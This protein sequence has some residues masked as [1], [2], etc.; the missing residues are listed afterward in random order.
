MSQERKNN[1][2]KEDAVLLLNR[3]KRGLMRIVFGRTALIILLLAVQVLFLFT[4]FFRLLGQSHLLALAGSGVISLIM[5]LIIVNNHHED[6]SAKLTWVVLVM[7]VPIVAIPLYWFVAMDMGHR[8]VHR[9]LRDIQRESAPLVRPGQAVRHVQQ[10]GEGR[11][12]PEADQLPGGV[13]LLL[14]PDHVL[15]L[16]LGQEG[17]AAGLGRVAGRLVRQ[18][19]QHRRQLQHPHG[20][21]R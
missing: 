14:E 17:A 4:A 8:L 13:G 2:S 20:F 6:S 21:F 9:R 18:E 19:G 12:P 15:R 10:A 16:G 3:G 11:G 1:S 7:V 5:A